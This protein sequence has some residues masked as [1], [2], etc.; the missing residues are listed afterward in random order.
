MAKPISLEVVKR[1]AKA[2]ESQGVVAD[3]SMVCQRYLSIW[4]DLLGGSKNT[5]PVA[6][7]TMTS[8]ANSA[9]S[10]IEINL[11]EKQ[12]VPNTTAIQK[13]VSM[14]SERPVVDKDRLTGVSAP[15]Q[16]KAACVERLFLGTLT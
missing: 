11:L 14:A 5:H 7:V 4:S 13:R 9:S 1:R 16:L 12:D 8:L 10:V 2:Q 15:L 3:L 6:P